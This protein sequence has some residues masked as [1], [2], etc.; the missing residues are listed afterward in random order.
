MYGWFSI[1]KVPT[2]GNEGKCNS[3]MGLRAGKNGSGAS[4]A[5]RNKRGKSGGCA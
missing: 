2:A 3:N 1:G 5:E 4:D